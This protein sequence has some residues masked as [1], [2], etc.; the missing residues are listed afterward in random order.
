VLQRGVEQY[1]MNHIV[2]YARALSFKTIL[3][4][5]IPTAKNSMVQEFFGQ[6]GF[7]RGTDGGEAGTQWR[8]EVSRYVPRE[9]FINQPEA[10]AQ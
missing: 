2:E 10:I 7:E 5:Y 8:L 6:F 1:A 3:G 9:V 4:R